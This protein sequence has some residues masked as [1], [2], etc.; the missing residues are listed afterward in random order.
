MGL[1]KAEAIEILN[2]WKEIADYLGKGVRTVQRYER[3]LGL[4][5][6]RPAGKP[7]GSVIATKAELSAW[8]S[9]SPIRDAFRLPLRAV[10]SAETV[11]G[12]KQQVTLFHRL[13]EESAKLRDEMRAAQEA[14]KASIQVVQE[15]LVR[16]S[17]DS[18]LSSRL[19][20][21]DPKR[22]VN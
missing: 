11:K 10:D 19:Q 8:I 20:T 16:V 3:Q 7:M 2:G 5:I 14:L 6:R 13:Q 18:Q 12:L 4:P 21:F 15:N 9:A 17:G 22:R 1:K